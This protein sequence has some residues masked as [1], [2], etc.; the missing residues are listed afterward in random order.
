MYN[1]KPQKLACHDR[2]KP[3]HSAPRDS[4]HFDHSMGSDLDVG[5]STTATGSVTTTG[6]LEQFITPF[7]Y[8]ENAPGYVQ[9]NYHAQTRH[10]LNL[11]DLP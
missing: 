9:R 6:A 3:Q 4:F 1:A 7:H 8:S 2:I 11:S 10:L 5:T